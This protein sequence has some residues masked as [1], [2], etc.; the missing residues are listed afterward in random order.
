[1]QN[2]NRLLVN[3]IVCNHNNICK[4]AAF[5][6]TCSKEGVNIFNLVYLYKD[7]EYL[8]RSAF[9]ELT[10]SI[11]VTGFVTIATLIV[12]NFLKQNADYSRVFELI[13]LGIFLLL[14]YFGRVIM[15][16]YLLQRYRNASFEKL[17]LVSQS[18]I[19][20]R[21]ISEIRER[22]DWRYSLSGIVTMDPYEDR[23]IQDINV[24]TDSDHMYERLEDTDYDSVLIVPN[25]TGQEK[26]QNMIHRFFA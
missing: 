2:R 19:A 14:D 23:S 6:S 25:H 24:I 1:M 21:I 18:D 26:L 12:I 15:R 8:Q 11:K 22:I 13:F 3:I 9:G 17:I 4:S 16:S 7:D 10:E 5:V 20:D